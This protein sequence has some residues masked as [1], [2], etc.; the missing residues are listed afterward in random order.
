MTEDLENPGLVAIAGSIADGTSVD[1]DKAASDTPASLAELRL[2][3]RIVQAHRRVV[4]GDSATTAPP[5]SVDSNRPA[6]WGHL[7]I[8]DTIGSGSF[9]VVYKALDERLAVNV[10]LKLMETPRETDAAWIS[11]A[12]DEAKR[13]ARVQHPNVVRVYGADHLEGHLGIWMEL[14]EGRTLAQLLDSQ[15]PLSAREAAN[16]GL[17]LTR[18]VAAVHR[19]GLVHA[20]IKAS[21]VM[22]AAGGRT[23]LM[24]FGAAVEPTAKTSA[25]R[26]LR[27]TP[28]YVAPEIFHGAQLSRASDVY[29]LGVLLFHLVTG[30]YP[31]VART[32]D[33]LVREHADGRRRLL[34]DVRPDLPDEFVRVVDRALA[35]RP[36]D[37]YQTP[38]ELE[39]A[40]ARYLD[41]SPRSPVPDRPAWRKLALAGAVLVLAIAAGWMYRTSGTAGGADV[42]AS[43]SYGVDAAFYRVA[44]SGEERLGE[45]QRLAPGDKLSF[46]LQASVPAFLYIV[47]EPE[48]G[49]PFL[50]FPL[51]GDQRQNPLPANVQA[52]VPAA[53]DWQ[54]TAAGGR[55][56][57]VV[58]VSPQ[59]V[60]AF[61]DAFAGLPSP[62]EGERVTSAA[63][64]A[65]ALERLR[66]VGGLTPATITPS[67][68]PR[69]SQM[70]TT[71]LSSQHETAQGLWI[72]RL[73][74]ENPM[75]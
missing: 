48:E 46:K 45:G 18:A 71:P 32:R 16:I 55:E 27:G 44:N 65:A 68:G 5:L 51:P 12:L 62:R 31:T 72:R 54:V 28:A 70:F 26:V 13:L 22:R 29:A 23:V 21:N 9:G 73:T 60:P 40:L 3:E 14:V 61:E 43:T 15:G 50:L 37:R 58:F 4:G 63:L 56:H 34:R 53:F 2:V 24:D 10:A 35:A 69:F 39:A 30:E 47:N 49:Q 19:V 8:V 7:R 33:E 25:T 42:S 17:D 66:S 57:F 59:R 38:G 11:T 67:T 75:P 36:A 52:R 74:L 41:P 6:A 1:W 64:P 20:D